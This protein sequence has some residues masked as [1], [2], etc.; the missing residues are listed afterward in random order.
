MPDRRPEGTRVVTGGAGAIGSVLVARLLSEGHRV[1]VLDDFSSGSRDRLPTG[2]AASQLGVTAVRLGANEP[3]D[4]PFRGASEVWHL[5]ANADVRRGPLDPRV[6]LTSGTVATFQVLEAA[7]RCDVPSVVFSSSSVVYGL[8]T[9]FPTPESYGPLQPESLY[10]AAK[11]AAE[12]LLSAYAHTY[13]LS[14]HIFRFANIVDGRANH[15]ILY[16]FFEKLRAD[17]SR[18]EVL[19]DGRQ[20]KSYLRT[21]ECVEGMLI[22]VRLARARVNLYNLGSLDRISVRE[23]AEK[24]VA[25]HGRRAAIV[26]T[27]GE[28][29]WVG[30]VPQQLLSIDRIRALGWQPKL[31]SAE[32]IDRTVAEMATSR[33]L[34]ASSATT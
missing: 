33:G 26:Y 14:A 10:G 31:S 9:V 7:R 4:A 2:A 3:P 6:D 18:L 5:A 17:P 28:R 22:G 27:G 30:D 34:R 19:G 16:D 1:E 23:I 11:L 29:G 15:G 24:V 25:A 12:G 21:E 8:P 20:A 32:A 13:G